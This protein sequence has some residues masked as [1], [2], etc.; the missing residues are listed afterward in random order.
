MLDSMGVSTTSALGAIAI[1]V[2]GLTNIAGTLA[3]GYLGN[4][5]PRKYLL[6]AIY[7]GRTLA[8]AAFIIFPITPLT[9]LVFSAFMGALWV[10]TIP[11]TSGLVGYIY[12]LRYMGTLYG[13]V[14]LSLQIG[15]FVGF[16]LGGIV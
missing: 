4:L 13:I 7:F 8:A 10:A 5:F 14:F 6:S 2:I 15:C 3:A 16:W 9:G 12:G 11:L 1:S